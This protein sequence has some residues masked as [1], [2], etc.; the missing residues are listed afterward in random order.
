MFKLGRKR[1]EWKVRGKQHLLTFFISSPLLFAAIV[2]AADSSL[3]LSNY[4]GA[5]DASS[6]HK[7]NPMTTISS[8]IMWQEL[9]VS[10]GSSTK[11]EV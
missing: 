2:C 9:D 4:W 11:A 1:E 5:W 6:P 3:S 10:N 7:N 8:G